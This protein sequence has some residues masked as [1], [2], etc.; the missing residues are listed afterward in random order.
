MSLALALLLTV[1]DSIPSH[2]TQT[3]VAIYKPEPEY[4]PEERA[5]RIDEKGIP[6]ELKIVRPL[7]PRLDA[8]ALATAAKWR[9][10]PG[11][12]DGEA[13]PVQATLA[14]SFRLNAARR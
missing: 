13:V 11:T 12:K 8:Q 10:K 9:F 6:T 3:P 7:N 2:P 14:I 1:A 4:T 5:A